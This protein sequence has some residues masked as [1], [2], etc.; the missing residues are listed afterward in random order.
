M[1]LVLLLKLLDLMLPELLAIKSIRKNGLKIETDA[2]KLSGRVIIVGTAGEKGN[3]V[4]NQLVNTKK[5]DL[6]RLEGRWECYQMQVVKSPM[7]GV[8]EALVIVGSDKR[9]ALYGMMHIS[10]MMGVSPWVWWSDVLPA[11]QSSVTLPGRECNIISKEPSI[12][13]RGI[14][15]NDE[16]PSLTTWTD[17]RYGGRNQYFYRQ[18]YELLIRLK[19]NY[20]WP[21]M[22]GDT[23]SADGV[24][25]SLAS[26][27]LADK[28]GIVMGTS[29]HEPLYRA[30]SEWANYYRNDLN[31]TSAE[32]WNLYNIPGQEGY[33][34]EVNKEIEEFWTES[35]IRNKEF[36]NICTVGM[37][38][39]NDS[40]LPAAD[41]PPRYA[42]LLNYII[43]TQKGI[44]KDHKDTNPTQLVIYKEVEDA[45]YAGELYNKD[46]MKQTYA[47]FCDDNWAYMRTL[48]TLDQQKQI[49][50]SG[51]YYHF[52]YVGA[53]K[54]Y[55]W[56]QNTQISTIWDQMSIAYDYGIEG[57][58]IAN[59]GDLKPMEINISYFLDLA[60]DYEYLGTAGHKRI[61][62]YKFEWAKQQFSRK[63]GSGLSDEECKEAANLIDRYLD[64]ETKRVVE[65][66][67]YNTVDTCSDMYSIDNYNEALIILEEC[68]D[69]M[70]RT[71]AL[72]AKVPDDV[73]AS[74]Y[75]LVYY[76][77]MAV[78]NV[79]KIQIYAALNNKYAKLGLTVAN[80]YAKLCQEAIDLDNELFDGYNE[81][82]PGVVESGK[83]WSGM[84]S[85]GQNYHIGLQA[86]DR[87]SGKLPDLMTVNPESS[88]EMQILVEDITDSF[89]NVVTE[90][91]T[92]LPTFNSVSDETFKIQLLTKGSAYKFKATADKWIKLSTKSGKVAEEKVIEVS[93]N[94]KKI[95]KDSEGMIVITSGEQEVHVKV[96]AKVI[97][98]AKLEPKTYVMTHDYVTLD[99]AN[100]SKKVDGKGINNQ[101]KLVKNEMIV[102]P[103]NGKY[104]STVRTSSSTIT[105]ETVDDLKNAPYVEYKVYIPAKGEYNLESQFNPTSNLIYGK[106][107]L[108]YGI[109]IDNGE[110]DIINTLVKDYLAGTWKQGT[111]AA[112]IEN[113]GRRSYKQ[114]ITLDEGIHTIR[115]YQCDPNIALIRMTLY[116]GKLATVYGSP[117]ES[118]FIKN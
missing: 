20:L 5:I 11:V 65:H 18:V 48:P 85:C 3:D 61:D 104:L 111:W 31:Y 55:T 43:N 21:A 8:D 83:K 84:I 75:Q 92:K 23:F 86:W 80:K 14:F 47:M 26:A 114:N 39:E 6:K 52:D 91:E 35:V 108:R 44:L 64:L 73:K 99:V 72:W 103:D 90:G 53:P 1:V 63:D 59:V 76:P 78:P 116:K 97:D 54:S 10:E 62:E 88:S 9:G 93:I 45:W 67:L 110:I 118:T 12:R 69:I 77:A 94:W 27:K 106:E 19:A 56:V 89:K 100:F 42:D 7:T 98:N 49:A 15:L 66:V 34:P 113:N 2:K 24:G 102:I 117:A 41:D 25:D 22:W 107:Q 30:G 74:F 96:E 95:N 50:G 38:G 36:E 46:C 16:A 51:M 112:D 105:Y 37:R 4:I 101:G 17:K 68:D 115:Y 81:K 82:M 29:H 40:T 58:W 32:A 79:L 57:V 109:S 87:D 28:Y 33:H 60:Y 13:Y 70:K 71:E